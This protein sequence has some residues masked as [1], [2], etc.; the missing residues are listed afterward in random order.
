MIFYGV[1]GPL[2]HWISSWLSKR[3]QRVT[4]DGKTSGAI[5]VKSGVPQGTVL[6]PLMFL[7]YINVINEGVTSSARLFADDCAIHKLI[8]TPQDAEQLQNDLQKII[9]WTKTWQMKVNVKKCA[10]LR[11]TRSLSPIPYDNTLASHN[12]A[13]KR[14]HT[15]LGE[16]I[17]SNMTWS[18]HI[19][20][21]S[22][23]STKV[24]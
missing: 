7:V 3:Q 10:V 1:R 20:T 14:L 16:E 18:S 23:K 6:G 21:I 9:K 5:P 4:V 22:N 13:I 24:I 11:C 2:L 15:Y 8:K 12:I 19:Q 17:D